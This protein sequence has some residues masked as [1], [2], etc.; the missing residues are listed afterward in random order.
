M[1]LR[2]AFYGADI[3][4]G[5]QPRQLIRRQ[6]DAVA[7][8]IGRYMKPMLLQSLIPQAKTIT[9]PVEDFYLISA[10]SAPT[11]RQPEPTAR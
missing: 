10:D 4:T 6:F 1:Q 11:D 9:L 2:V 3:Q 7:G 8:D 5:K